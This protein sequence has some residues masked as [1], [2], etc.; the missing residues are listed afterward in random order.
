MENRIIGSPYKMLGFPP[1]APANTLNDTE[2][3]AS[4]G[5]AVPS[6]K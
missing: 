2:S 4:S 1:F 3:S 5:K 6:Q